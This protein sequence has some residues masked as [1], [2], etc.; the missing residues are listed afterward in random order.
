MLLA[1]GRLDLRAGI[2][3][4]LQVRAASETVDGEGKGKGD[5]PLL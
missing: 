2:D 4:N 3:L 1:L 5:T